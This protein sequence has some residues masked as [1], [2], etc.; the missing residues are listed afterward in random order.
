MFGERINPDQYLPFLPPNIRQ[1]RPDYGIVGPDWW[2]MRGSK[3]RL[4][5]SE[6]RRLVVA[7]AAVASVEVS[8]VLGEYGNWL[9][10]WK[11]SHSPRT[12]VHGVTDMTD[13]DLAAAFG[14][15]DRYVGMR[16][17]GRELLHRNGGSSA[18]HHKFIR[19]EDYLN[20]PGPGT[21]NDGDPNVSVLL[22][23]EI[24]AA[25]RT[26]LNLPDQSASEEKFDYYLM[27]QVRAE[28][29][30]RL[31]QLTKSTMQGL[32]KSK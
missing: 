12:F 20:I 14:L 30:R 28:E 15:I 24:K 32:F 23:D 16:G 5:S 19:F 13:I 1:K 8:P 17:H 6:P 21:G 4:T 27:L 22:D 25:A 18:E 2:H 9:V 31:D 3:V 29:R 26:L 7:N 11:V 10:D